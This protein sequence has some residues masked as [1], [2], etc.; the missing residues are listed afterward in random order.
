MSAKKIEL[1]TTVLD[2]CATAVMIM[3]AN[4]AR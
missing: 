1:A 4:H 2:E 3:A